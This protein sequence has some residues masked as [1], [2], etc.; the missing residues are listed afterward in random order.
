MARVTYLT[1]LTMARL[2]LWPWT[3]AQAQCW[4]TR[5]GVEL[6]PAS[7]KS[8]SLIDPRNARA[9]QLAPRA[10]SANPGAMT[11]AGAEDLVARA[12]DAERAG[13][14]DKAFALWS[15]LVAAYPDHPHALFLRG[16]RHMEA[17][18]AAG[19]LA[20]FT[21]SEAL[22]ASLPETPFFIAVCQR[23]LRNPNAALDAVERALALDPY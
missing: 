9:A 5:P 4:R 2:T 15:E 17:G 12:K 13:A 14:R 22:D 23:H 8:S 3:P 16:R 11:A 7:A 18:D 21:Q 1:F 20:V 10:P 19:A 6:T